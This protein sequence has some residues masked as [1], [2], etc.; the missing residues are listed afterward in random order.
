MSLQNLDL[1]IVERGG[2][3]YRMN[4]TELAKFLN[5]VNDFTAADISDRDSGT[6]VPALPAD[7]YQVGDRVFVVDASADATV[8]AGWAIY[9]VNS[10]GPVVFQKV[11]DQESLDVVVNVAL[12]YIPAANQGTITNSA[13]SDVII[14][15]VDETNAGHATPQMFANSHVPAVTAGTASTNPIQIDENTQELSFSISDLD[16]LPS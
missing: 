12:G 9:R 3:Q 7:G 14:P 16:P 13:G 2:V 1:L 11:Q 4:A 15:A 8:D 10:I 6:A 5:T